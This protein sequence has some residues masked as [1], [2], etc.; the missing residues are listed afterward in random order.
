MEPRRIGPV[1]SVQEFMEKVW[2]E[3]R[4]PDMAKRIF[5]GQA[6]EWD[7]LPRLFRAGQKPQEFEAIEDKL[8]AEFKARSPYLLPS[9]P[10]D[11]LDWLSLA[12]HHGLPT[13][14]LDWSSNPL[15]ALFFAVESPGAPKPTVWFYDATQ[16]QLDHGKNLEN[17]RGLEV[18]TILEPVRHSQRVAAQAGWH[19]VHHAVGEDKN[20]SVRPMNR[21]DGDSGRLVLVSVHP[22]N[23]GDVRREL[24][25][26]GIHSATVYADLSSLCKE[27]QDELGVPPGMR[28]DAEYWLK[29]QREVRVH[30]LALLIA[31]GLKR[32]VGDYFQWM[33]EVN[34]FGNTAGGYEPIEESL[35]MEA[36]KRANGYSMASRL[37]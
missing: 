6:D 28:R 10:S 26:M 34:E 36:T 15:I 1:K 5:R 3:P 13:R 35:L 25:D 4:K 2:S 37:T 16:K 24:K 21:T 30:V 29:R 11:K 23:A 20:T 19:T 18:T 17:V 7:L 9:T 31:N 33:Y 22:N 27:I 14:L 8:L 12:Q 32:K